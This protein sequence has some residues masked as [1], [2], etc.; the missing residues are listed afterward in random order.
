M[1]LCC[2]AKMLPLLD[3]AISVG[4]ISPR[5]PSD[6]PAC[7]ARSAKDLSFGNHHANAA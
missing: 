1:E 3:G 7:N 2:T 6:Q 5:I 4:W